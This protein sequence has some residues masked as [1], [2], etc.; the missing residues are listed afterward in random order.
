MHHRLLS[1]KKTIAF[2]VLGAALAVTAAPSPIQERA[3]RFLALANAGYQ[4]LYRVNNEAQWLAVTDGTPIHDPAPETAAKTPAPFK[5][6]PPLI[7]E[8]KKQ[9]THPAPPNELTG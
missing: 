5:G 2:L 4:G 9:L 3:D 8:A 1:S 7:T 6:K